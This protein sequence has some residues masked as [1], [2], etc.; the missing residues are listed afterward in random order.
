M[1]KFI[2]FAAA[3]AIAIVASFSVTAPSSAFDP[4]VGIAAGIIGFAAGAAIVSAAQHDRY[5]S[6]YY[7]DGDWQD[8]VIACEDAY[9]SYS[10]RTDTFVGYDGYAHICRL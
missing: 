2:A 8:H 10:P 4:G 7:S 3:G 5:Y 6:D 9:R 1:N